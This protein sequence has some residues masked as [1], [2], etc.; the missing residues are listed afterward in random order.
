MTATAM[1]VGWL[2][3]IDAGIARAE[4][5]ALVAM[6]AVLVLLPLLQIV[7][8]VVGMG[9]IPWGHELIRLL[10][11]WLGF[12]GASLATRERRHIC[13][14]LL[15]RFLSPRG[16]AG[17]NLAV[18]AIAIALLGWLARVALAFIGM[19]D[20]RSAILSIPDRLVYAIIPI[21]LG[22]MAF[23]FV[24]LASEEIRGLR[25]GDFRYLLGPEAEGR[26]Y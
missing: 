12:V 21:S 11:M 15:D 13:L 5:W 8:R 26:L 1:P 6:V 20:S 14:D 7:L 17:F 23:R 19:V 4:R 10:V 9:G 22:I 18:E 3:R 2:H 25:S 16:K 24:V